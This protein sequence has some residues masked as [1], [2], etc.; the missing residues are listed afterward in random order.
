MQARWLHFVFRIAG[1][2]KRELQAEGAEAFRKL[3]PP[4]SGVSPST[5]DISIKC[6][7]ND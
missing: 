4:F 6:M 2:R 5:L 1:P 3:P 7:K